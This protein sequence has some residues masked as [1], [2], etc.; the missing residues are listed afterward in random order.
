MTD[1]RSRKSMDRALGM[2]R[3]IGVF[4]DANLGADKLVAG[5]GTGSFETRVPSKPF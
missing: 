2:D 3:P 1:Q 5:V 4:F